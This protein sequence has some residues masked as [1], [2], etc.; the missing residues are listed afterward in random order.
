MD[1]GDILRLVIIIGIPLIIK[2]FKDKKEVT[3]KNPYSGGKTVIKDRENLE[4]YDQKTSSDYNDDYPRD[5][6]MSY[7]KEYQSREDYGSKTSYEKDLDLFKSKER[8]KQ[9]KASREGYTME[10]TEEFQERKEKLNRMK[11]KKAI[12]KVKDEIGDVIGQNEIGNVS[13]DYNFD[14]EDIVKGIIMS[15]ILSKPKA[16]RKAK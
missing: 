14:R 1:F 3:N 6:G 8:S 13:M 10:W 12:K 4:N 9:N 2:T 11:K 7:D 15:E 16:L 5:H